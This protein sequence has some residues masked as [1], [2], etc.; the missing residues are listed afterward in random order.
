MPAPDAN[1]A[2]LSVAGAGTG[3]YAGTSA[4]SDARTG[5]DSYSEDTYPPSPLADE[6]TPRDQWASDPLAKDPLAT[7]PLADDPYRDDPLRGGQR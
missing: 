3:A 7:D 6:G 4:Y 2:G 5:A 1:T